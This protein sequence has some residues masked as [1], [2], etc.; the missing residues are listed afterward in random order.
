MHLSALPIALF[1]TGALAKDSNITCVQGLYMIV[2]RGTGEKEGSGITGSLAEDIADRIDDSA[3]EPLD[4][5]AAF[6]DPDYLYSERDG[7]DIMQDMITSYHDA[8]PDGKMAVFGYSQGGQVTS[9]A[10][11]GSSGISGFSEAAPLPTSLVDD[12]VVAIIVFGD[13]THV[14]EAPYNRGTSQK[15]GVW[16]R[17]N[18]TVCEDNYTG[19]MRSY[20]DTGDVFCDL[21]TDGEVHRLYITN[22]GDDVANFVVQKYKDMMSKTTAT[23]SGTASGSPSETGDS[24]NAAAGLTPSLALAAIAP[25]VL[26]VLELVF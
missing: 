17:E 10:F 7:V 1:A 14:A 18:I 12:S 6:S 21:G 19:I 3:V 2:A 8:C 9:D 15:N 5:P 26:V 16:P 20:C 4:Y 11:C 13:P 23:A 22:Y 24:D 25:L